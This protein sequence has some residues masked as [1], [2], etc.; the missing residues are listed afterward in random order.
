MRPNIKISH[1]LNGRVKD[2]AAEHDLDLTD[3]YREIITAGLEAVES[4]SDS[5]TETD[6]GQTDGPPVGQPGS[7][8]PGADERIKEIVADVSESWED[9]PD[10]LAARRDAA[11]AALSLAF[12]RGS[13]SKSEA[14]SDVRPNHEVDGQ[15]N[16]TW[17]RKN[18]RP[19]LQEVG[20]HAPGRGYVIR[21]EN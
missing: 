21:D 5:E 3:A 14:L 1:T 13:L 9:A 6:A 19:V 2:Y 8:V 15:S 20:E 18:V 16:E 4:Q 7:E 11:R 10:R 12:E 17:W